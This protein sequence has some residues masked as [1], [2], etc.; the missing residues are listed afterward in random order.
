MT[1]WLFKW[2]IM[3]KCPKDFQLK[4]EELLFCFYITV[5][6]VFLNFTTLV[7]QNRESEFDFC[8][9]LETGI[10]WLDDKSKVGSGKQNYLSFVL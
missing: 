9:I 4:C 2:F 3:Q 8:L 10:S 6:Y 1:E 5:N 7:R